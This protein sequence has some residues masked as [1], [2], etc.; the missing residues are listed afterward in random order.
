MELKNLLRDYIGRNDRTWIIYNIDRGEIELNDDCYAIGKRSFGE[1]GNAVKDVLKELFGE[2]R[3][4][5]KAF[6]AEIYEN[7]KFRA[8]VLALGFEGLLRFNVAKKKE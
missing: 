8:E 2:Y 7:D 6:N 4:I 5:P 1:V 3:T